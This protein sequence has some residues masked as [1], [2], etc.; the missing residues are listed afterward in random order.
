M[1]KQR[2]K[3]ES[4]SYGYFHDRDPYAFHAT[5]DSAIKGRSKLLA[6]KKR[7]PRVATFYSFIQDSRKID[8]VR[9]KGSSRFKRYDK[10]QGPHTFP[11]HGIH[12]AIAEAKR[13]KKLDDFDVLIPSKT[14]FK[15][16]VDKE[17][18][19]SHAKRPRADLAIE[20]YDKVRKRYDTLKTSAR[21]DV[22]DIKY[23][24]TINKLV[25]MHP[26]GSRTYKGT[27]AKSGA[28]AG[29]GETGKAYDLRPQIDMPGSPFT[30]MKAAN[31]R[32]KSIWKVV[33]TFRT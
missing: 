19:A 18:P 26:Y 2:Y 23:A 10:P 11:H 9:S 30:D 32:M 8:F 6:I 17:I 31:A 29:K 1:P 33:K 4:M 13:L 21:D 7:R 3:P 22:A 15:A 5:Q 28:L 20:H 16:I 12:F 24:H 14:D 27:G 25:Q